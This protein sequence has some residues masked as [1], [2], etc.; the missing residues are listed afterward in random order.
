MRHGLVWG[1]RFR[2]ATF[3]LGSLIGV[4]SL[5]VLP[6]VVFISVAGLLNSQPAPL[7]PVL[8][9]WMAVIGCMWLGSVGIGAWYNVADTGLTRAERCAEISRVLVLAPIAG[10]A[11]S[12][13]ALRA[14]AEWIAGR[15]AVS[16]QPTP[17]TKAADAAIDWENTR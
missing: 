13:A 2:I 14:A 16:W 8:T 17:K 3:A 11:E 6:S 1:T 9:I 10:I 7:S 15:R 5:L 4:L 12:S